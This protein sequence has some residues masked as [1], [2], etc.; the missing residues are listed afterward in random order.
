MKK[1]SLFIS[2]AITTFILAILAGVI[3]ARA[4]AV[5]SHQEVPVVYPTITDTEV[6]SLTASPTSIPDHI[7]PQEASVIAAA[8]LGNSQIYS[9]ETASL[10]GMDVY[11][12]T[13]S[14]GDIVYVSPQGHVLLTTYLRRYVPAPPSTGNQ[15]SGGQSHQP[16]PTNPPATSQPPAHH[17]DDGG[18]DD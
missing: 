15:A 10:Y 14:S 6:P 17:G 3:K 1:S 11:K 12:V 9:V 8:V 7:S 4:D 13:F 16:A 2:A 18:G 5:V